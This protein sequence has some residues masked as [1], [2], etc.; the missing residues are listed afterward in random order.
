MSKAR[1]YIMAGGTFAC[2]LGIGFFMQAQVPSHPVAAMQ[3]GLVPVLDK[4]VKISQIELTSAAPAPPAAMP[5]PVALPAAPVT[6]AVAEETVTPDTLPQEEVAPTFICDYE[7]DAALRK[8]AMV[9]LTVSA[10]CRINE[11]FTVHHNGMM[12]NAVTDSAGHSSLEVPA[13]SESAVFIVSFADGEGALA[14]AD[15]DTLSLYDRFVVQWSGSSDSLSLHAL[16]YGADFGDAGHIWAASTQDK[17]RG[18]AG[19]GGFLTRLGTPGTD[20]GLMAEVYT[21]PTGTTTRAG[22]V[23]L[24]V[25]ATVSQ[26]NCGRELEAQ[27]I[28]T[29]DAGLKVQDIVLAMPDCEAI[30]EF[31]VLKNL[32]NDL[33][34]AQN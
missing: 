26:T 3:S 4:P 14:T 10:P 13:L 6:L 9:E 34:I 32:F 22:D 5:G 11:R 18:I 31:L 20:Q 25:E 17:A 28:A 33:K 27:T 1:R 21:F 24:R 8:G 30:G 12:F 16:E 29:G 23:T 2:A 19:E 15:V 7:M